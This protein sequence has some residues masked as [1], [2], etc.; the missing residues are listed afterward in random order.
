MKERNLVNAEELKNQVNDETVKI[1]QEENANQL[2]IHQ[3]GN[4]GCAGC[5]SAADHF[6]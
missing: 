5:D 6:Q 1:D 3:D 4:L 2:P